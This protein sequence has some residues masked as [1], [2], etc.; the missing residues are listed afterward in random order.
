MSIVELDEPAPD[1]VV[2]R[3]LTGQLASADPERRLSAAAAVLVTEPGSARAQEEMAEAVRRGDLL[4]WEREEW[5]DR[6]PAS[7][8][9]WALSRGR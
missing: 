7:V 5:M 3:W 1:D 9:D 2:R 6:R 8:T 4:P